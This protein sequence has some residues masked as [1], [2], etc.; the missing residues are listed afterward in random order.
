MTSNQSIN[1]KKYQ[2]NIPTVKNILNYHKILNFN[3]FS[4]LQKC[5]LAKEKKKFKSYKVVKMS[6]NI[7]DNKLEQEMRFNYQL[8]LTFAF[9]FSCFLFTS[10]YI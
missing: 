6:I 3:G 10:I 5:V 9:T 8:S 2:K 4:F 1:V 7:N